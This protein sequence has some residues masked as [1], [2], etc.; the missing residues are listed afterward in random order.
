MLFTVLTAFVKWVP[1]TP[2]LR[3]ALFVADLPLVAEPLEATVLVEA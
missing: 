1:S 2:W 3:G